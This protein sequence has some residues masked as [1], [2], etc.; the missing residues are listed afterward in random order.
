MSPENS[1]VGTLITHPQPSSSSYKVSGVAAD[2][3]RN[4]FVT[5]DATSDTFYEYQNAATATAPVSPISIGTTKM[6]AS[7]YPYRN[8]VA[9]AGGY[10]MTEGT[11]GNYVYTYSVT[12]GGSTAKI[13][14]TTGGSTVYGAAEASDGTVL[15]GNSCCARAGGLL[16][17]D[18]TL[19]AASAMTSYSSLFAGGQNADR[20]IS[21][22]G[23]NN[24]WTGGATYGNDPTGTLNSVGETDINYSPLSPQGVEPPLV[25][26]TVGT[27]SPGDGDCG[28]STGATA[29][30]ECQVFSG[31]SKPFLLVNAI[32]GMAID[33]SGN[34]IVAS[35]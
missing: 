26:S 24:I 8:I 9:T 30:D 15:I 2:Q 6:S 25:Y 33:S 27:Y 20:S 35:S 18:P 23:A 32:Y 16:R 10:L 17:I 29:A 13:T 7:G 4:I 22:D 5:P 31:F 21:I 12:N 1:A 34:D 3:N 11:G 19:A 14:T 28:A